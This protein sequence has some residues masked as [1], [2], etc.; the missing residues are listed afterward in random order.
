MKI[1]IKVV[2]PLRRTPQELPQTSFW[3]GLTREQMQA[4]LADGNAE[5]M[6]NSAK[7]AVDLF[8]GSGAGEPPTRGQFNRGRA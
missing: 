6:R 1:Q 7:G 8:Y 5:R 4:A 3:V 2:K